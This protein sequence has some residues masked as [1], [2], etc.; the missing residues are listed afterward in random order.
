M[1]AA[2]P[3]LEL[4]ES[5]LAGAASGQQCGPAW[6]DAGTSPAGSAAATTEAHLPQ[7]GPATPALQPA[8]AA[9]RL[10]EARAAAGLEASQGC[11]AG[12]ARGEAGGALQRGG[13]GEAAA[14]QG[15]PQGR[16]AGERQWS[17][18][19]ARSQAEAEAAAR[20]RHLADMRAHFAEVRS[21]GWQAHSAS[22]Q[23]MVPNENDIH[24][25]CCTL[26]GSL[27]R[28]QLDS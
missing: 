2:K 8:A 26:S 18:R 3:L 27:E 15:A 9:A 11:G 12:G 21:Y 17:R 5:P 16:R 7:E 23:R 14:G 25:Q 20:A 19:A 4:D 22:I 10:A 13:M 6:L 24:R 28:P 1:Q